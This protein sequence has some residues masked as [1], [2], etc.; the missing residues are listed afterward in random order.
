MR[1]PHLGE[2]AK[3]PEAQCHP[4]G[5]AVDATGL[6]HEGRAHYPGR[7]AALPPATGVLPALRGVGMGRQKSA[8]AVVVGPTGEG[9]NVTRRREAGLSM[10]K[11]DADDGAEMRHAYSKGSGRKPREQEMGAS[12]ATARPTPSDPEA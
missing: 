11:R 1:R 5:A 3:K 8:E 7:S 4:E 6:W 12:T 10:V 9:L 2:G